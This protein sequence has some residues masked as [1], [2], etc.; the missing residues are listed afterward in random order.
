M[1]KRPDDLQ[2]K[3]EKADPAIRAYVAELQ[4]RNAKL[5]ADKIERDGIIKAL[6]K[7]D[8]ASDLGER[9]RRAKQRTA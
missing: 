3:L 9:L 8:S 6:K 7:G 5:Q 2:T 1:A 4:K